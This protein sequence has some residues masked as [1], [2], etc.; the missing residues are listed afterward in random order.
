[1]ISLAK[2]E[3]RST[4]QSKGVA[5]IDRTDPALRLLQYVRTN[6]TGTP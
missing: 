1:M 5:E 4:Y 6:P 3:E 2:E